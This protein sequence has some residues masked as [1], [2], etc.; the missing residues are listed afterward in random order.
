MQAS[1]EQSEDAWIRIQVKKVL[2]YPKGV[3][4]D[5]DE[6]DDVLALGVCWLGKV[7]RQGSQMGRRFLGAGLQSC[8]CQGQVGR[9][10]G[11]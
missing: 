11:T 4:R 7:I 8:Q 3:F 5:C 9:G 2:S 10:C 6:G 1:S